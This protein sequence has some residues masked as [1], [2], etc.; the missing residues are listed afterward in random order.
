MRAGVRVRRALCELSHKSRLFASL[1]KTLTDW[2]PKMRQTYSENELLFVVAET[3]FVEL[4]HS[5]MLG[6]D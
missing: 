6:K 2:L 4:N 5:E 1:R 3:P